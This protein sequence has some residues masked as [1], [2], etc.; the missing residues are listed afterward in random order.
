MLL[1]D[2]DVVAAAFAAA[3]FAAAFAAA[4]NASAA[5]ASSSSIDSSFSNSDEKCLVCN[6]AARTR[7]LKA[8]QRTLSASLRASLAAR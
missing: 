1:G 3:A 2:V 6:P 8:W 4:L 5:T 7:A